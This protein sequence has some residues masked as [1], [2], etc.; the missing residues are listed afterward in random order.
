MPRLIKPVTEHMTRFPGGVPESR[1]ARVEGMGVGG[2]IVVKPTLMS[3]LRRLSYA[4]PRVRAPSELG[5]CSLSILQWY[6]L[7]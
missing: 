6:S 1:Q 3:A 2:D 7:Q 5:T 4:I